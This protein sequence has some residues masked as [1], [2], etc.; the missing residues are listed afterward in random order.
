MIFAFTSTIAS[1]K[2]FINK[3][4][5]EVGNFHLATDLEN[6]KLTGFLNSSQIGL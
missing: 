5:H 3:V 4:A 6:E 2:H 1:C